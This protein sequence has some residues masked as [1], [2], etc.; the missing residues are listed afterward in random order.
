MGKLNCGFS[1]NNLLTQ[2]VK[3][4]EFYTF[5]DKKDNTKKYLKGTFMDIP[6]KLGLQPL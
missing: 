3:C 1:K 6:C 5:H 2:W 4:S